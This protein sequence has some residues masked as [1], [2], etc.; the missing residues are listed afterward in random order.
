MLLVFDK[1]DQLLS[2]RDG[3]YPTPRRGCQEHGTGTIRSDN[4]RQQIVVDTAAMSENILIIEVY[5]KKNI[6]LRGMLLLQF[7]FR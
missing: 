4:T 1:L 3:I 5:S 7:N 2:V 6:Y